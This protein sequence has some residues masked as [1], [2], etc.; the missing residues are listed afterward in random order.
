MASLVCNGRTLYRRDGYLVRSPIYKTLTIEPDEV[1]YYM[2]AGAYD[3]SGFPLRGFVNTPTSYGV[4]QCANNVATAFINRSSNSQ[5]WRQMSGS[6]AMYPNNLFYCGTYSCHDPIPWQSECFEMFA[7]Y[8]FTLP[9]AYKDAVIGQVKWNVQHKG[10]IACYMNARDKSAKNFHTIN[11]RTKGSNFSWIA[12]TD[13]DT[14]YWDIKV[15]AYSRL[16][17]VIKNM[18][19]S[20][21]DVVSMDVGLD[22]GNANEWEQVWTSA[23]NNG[24][25]IPICTPYERT[26][27]LSD[28]ITSFFQSNKSFWIVGIPN[29]IS[30]NDPK[31]SFINQG[32][33][34]N[35]FY[36]LACT[37]RTKNVTVNLKVKD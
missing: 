26:Y 14:R 12:G 37:W 19:N 18:Y 36:W 9:I 27:T 3:S 31:P 15:G 8:H 6:G 32:V 17:D 7:A 24:G 1:A 2:I 29:H 20:A 35:F 30:G 28:T 16:D 4:T 11:Y 10:Q 23:T 33:Q 21:Q 22:N 34:D 5:I 13:W 25:A